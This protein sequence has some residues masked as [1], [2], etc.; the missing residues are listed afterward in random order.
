M[1]KVTLIVPCRNEESNIAPFYCAAKSVFSNIDVDLEVLFIDDGSTDKTLCEIN[2]L[3]KKDARVK[4]I[5]F[6]RGFGKEAALFAGVR[7]CVQGADACDAAVVLDADLQHP[8]EVIPDMIKKWQEGFDVVEGMKANRGKESIAH[9]ALTY[10]FYSLMAHA[11]GMDMMHSSDYKLLDRK[12]LLQLAKIKE[13]NTFFRALSFWCGFKRTTVWYDVQDR[14]FGETKWSTIS[15]IK[16]AVHNVVS[17]SYAPLNAVTFFG[18]VFVVVALIATVMSISGWLAGKSIE[19]VPTLT[20]VVLFG[21]GAVMISLG[22]IGVYIAQ[23]YDEV[24][25]RPQYIIGEQVGEVPT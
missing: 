21:F 19:G 9:G 13:R 24:K 2:A 12:V 14:R 23:I 22:I 16:Y 20:I 6:S 10:L 15:L 17:F 5:S 3:H 18:M 8:I 25:C 4:G 7:Q 1:P 11:V